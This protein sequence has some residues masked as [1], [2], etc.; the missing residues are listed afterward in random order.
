MVGA[1]VVGAVVVG[2]GVV[3]AAVVGVCFIAPEGAVGCVVVG[4]FGATGTDAPAG[5]VGVAGGVVGATVDGAG[6]TGALVDGVVAG[7]C[8][9]AP[10]GGP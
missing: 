4:G 1:V 5:G 7:P 8:F 3:G 6:C 9:I 2:A 10:E